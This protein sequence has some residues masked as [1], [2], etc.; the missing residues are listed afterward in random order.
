VRPIFCVLLAACTSPSSPPGPTPA[1]PVL[2]S[3]AYYQGPPPCAEPGPVECEFEL[4]FCTDG[5]YTLLLGDDGTVGTYRIDDGVA[6]DDNSG[7]E[8]D[9]TTQTI[10]AGPNAGDGPLQPTTVVQDADVACTQ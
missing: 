5:T 1:D 9:F 6:I 3:D 10:T 7:F 8:F 2:P 4:A